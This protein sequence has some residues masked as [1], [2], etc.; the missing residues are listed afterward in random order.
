MHSCMS[1]TNEHALNIE[2]YQRRCATLACS[3]L[4]VSHGI[5]VRHLK[6]STLSY[7]LLSRDEVI[8]YYY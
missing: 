1:S 4:E 7:L 8:M 3:I 2:I 5:L 6:R